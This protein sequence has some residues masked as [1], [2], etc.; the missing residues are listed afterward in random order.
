MKKCYVSVLI[1]VVKLFRCIF[2]ADWSPAA[3][4]YW[5]MTD[6]LQLVLIALELC[7][8]L[9]NLDGI[10]FNLIYLLLI[11]VPRVLD[12]LFL[13]NMWISWLIWFCLS[14]SAIAG[15]CL[16]IRC[17]SCKRWLITS[18]CNDFNVFKDLW[19]IVLDRDH[20]VE[21]VADCVKLPWKCFSLW[22]FGIVCICTDLCILQE[23]NWRNHERIC[24]K[25][26][27][28]MNRDQLQGMCENEIFCRKMKPP[29][30]HVYLSWLN[31]V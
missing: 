15:S 18:I 5:L 11:D 1:S 14:L 17:V 3:G 12:S 27:N 22:I 16:N 6:H 21:I 13:V 23:F 2:L 20:L 25:H 7:L 4:C 8:C 9:L 26:A 31:I 30:A 19:R 28:V 29:H 10:G 24:R